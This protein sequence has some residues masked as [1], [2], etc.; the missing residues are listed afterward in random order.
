M[1][2]FPVTIHGGDAVQYLKKATYL[3]GGI[4]GLKSLVKG[5]EVHQIFKN[6]VQDI[7]S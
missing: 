5:L 3:K 6:V 4:Y 7:A 2:S 1:Y